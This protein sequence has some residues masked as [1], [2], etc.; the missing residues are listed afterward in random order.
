MSVKVIIYAITLHN[1]VMP[2]I[3]AYI[4]QVTGLSKKL[5]IS[6]TS[7]K[8]FEISLIKAIASYAYKIK[9]RML[10]FA[11]PSRWARVNTTRVPI[12]I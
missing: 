12:S 5:F 8:Y 9:K 4:F 2:V 7:N 10:E 11:I 3:N 1:T 6:I